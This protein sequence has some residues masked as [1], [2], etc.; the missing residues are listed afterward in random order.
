[1]DLLRLLSFG[2]QVHPVIHKICLAN[3]QICDMHSFMHSSKQYLG[4]LSSPICSD[5]CRPLDVSDT[6]SNIQVEHF[7]QLFLMSE[8]KQRKKTVR[9]KKR[10]ADCF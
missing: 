4:A 7:H 8:Y 9:K 10:F 2:V 6:L 3:A 5:P 1:M